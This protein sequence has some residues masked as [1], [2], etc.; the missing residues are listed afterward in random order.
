MSHS[1]ISSY[2]LSSKC[3]LRILVDEL[4]AKLRL[5]AWYKDPKNKSGRIIYKRKTMDFCD[6]VS[7]LI[8]CITQKK[9]VS[10]KAELEATTHTVLNGG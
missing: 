5:M 6:V 4:T 10:P 2:K 7:A 1:L 3:Y 8:I 9:F